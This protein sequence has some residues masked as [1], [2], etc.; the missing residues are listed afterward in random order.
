MIRAGANLTGHEE[1]FPTRLR[2]V[3]SLSGN[4][5]LERTYELVAAKTLQITEKVTNRSPEQML[6]PLYTNHIFPLE[7]RGAEQVYIRRP[8]GT[9]QPGRYPEGRYE[10][11]GWLGYEKGG[12]WALIN[13]NT[14]RGVEVRFRPEDVAILGFWVDNNFSLQLTTPPYRLDQAQSATRVH[15]I[16]FLG[17]EESAE[18]TGRKPGG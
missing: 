4:V 18:I 7:S 9:W 6:K 1:S 17:P 8:D 16:R 12:G 14:G 2:M 11:M 13:R 15:S 10:Q 5:E 3:A